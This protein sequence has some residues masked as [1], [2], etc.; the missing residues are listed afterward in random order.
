MPKKLRERRRRGD[1]GVTVTKY[2]SNR[3]PILRKASI[4]L[5]VVTIDGKRR[6]N[7]PTEYAGSEKEAH[8]LLKRMQ[9]RYL[10]GDDMTPSKQTLEAFLLRWLEHVK[11]T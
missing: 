11:A 9:A 5:G 1:G 2:D 6:R 8:D 7:R 10:A 4:S 3:N